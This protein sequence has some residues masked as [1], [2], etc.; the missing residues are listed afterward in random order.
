MC[1]ARCGFELGSSCMPDPADYTRKI[2]RWRLGRQYEW[3]WQSHRW[4]WISVS[5]LESNCEFEAFLSFEI[6][7]NCQINYE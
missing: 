3:Y 4:D 1:D 2:R 7:L 6:S 5:I